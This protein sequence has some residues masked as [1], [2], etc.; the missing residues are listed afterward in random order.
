MLELSE[1][2]DTFIDKI[3]TMVRIFCRSPIKNDVLQKNCQAEF[4]K[5][6]NL[7]MGTRT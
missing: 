7:I 5:E 2:I 1:K 4:G 6:F 3:Q